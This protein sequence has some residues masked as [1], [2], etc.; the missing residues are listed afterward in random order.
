MLLET[1]ASPTERSFGRPLTHPPGYGVT[2]PT[3]NGDVF[4][5]IPKGVRENHKM[6]RHI[7]S[8]CETDE[9]YRAVIMGL[10]SQKSVASFLF[11]CNLFAYTSVPKEVDDL[12][13]TIQH[14]PPLVVPFI[15]WPCQ[16][17]AA[18]DLLHGIWNSESV[19]VNKAREM[20]ATWLILA[21]S[22]WLYQFFPGTTGM[23]MSAEEALVDDGTIESL[24]GKLDF[25][26]SRQ[27][28]WMNP[29]EDRIKLTF[30]RRDCDGALIGTATS[31][32]KGRSRRPAFAFFD[33]AA[34]IKVLKKLWISM[35]ATT[36]C[37]I[38]NS[39]VNGPNFFSK[40]VRSDKVKVVTL[41]WWDHPKKGIG[42]Y[43]YKDPDSGVVKVSSP[44]LDI[45]KS[46][47]VDSMEIEQEH[48]MDPQA[49]GMSVF[50]LYTTQRQIS[51]Y[52][53]N[54]WYRGYLHVPEP[55]RL[56][57]AL[58]R[59]ASEP[60]RIAWQWRDADRGQDWLWWWGELE[61]DSLTGLYRPNQ[62][63]VYAIASDIGRGTGTSNSAATIWD[64]TRREKVGRMLSSRH[65][66]DQWA[67]MLMMVG[68]W[69]G[70]GRKT[71]F[72][73]WERNG[74]GDDSIW[75]VV[76]AMRY[77]WVYRKIVEDQTTRKRTTKPGWWSSDS[78]KAELL[79][80][81]AAALARDE[82]KNPDRAALEEAE[83]FVWYES[84]GCGVGEREDE[85]SGARAAHGDMVIADALIWYLQRQ[86]H[87]Q[88]PQ[89]LLYTR[90]A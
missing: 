32:E 36:G 4:W 34:F 48:N 90:P 18:A 22:R 75:T 17:D 46:R 15:T 39:T 7:L 37:R 51:K 1:T 63:S 41:P 81:Y 88:T 66:P 42:A 14:T 78:A 3:P 83:S 13:N 67:R 43:E 45:K 12:G 73:G 27:P 11:W 64:V 20:G 76:R 33:E 57:K 49:G 87:R 56:D 70:G 24:F 50:S 26:V 69:C 61:E 62:T 77:P 60:D 55:A 2:I 65:T 9:K 35:E 58:L 6:R 54:P 25:I 86:C 40:L 80:T 5:P 47:A 59:C 8:R 84:G 21:I 16:D 28:A 53:R 44:W 38:A 10:C 85:A 68:Y 19:V 82:F 23:L 74:A 52:A 30:R 29:P 72:L 89:K 79:V 31:A 71:A